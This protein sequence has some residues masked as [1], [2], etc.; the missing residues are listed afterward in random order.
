L[1]ILILTTVGIITFFADIE[2]ML[3]VIEITGLDS[4]VSLSFA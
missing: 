4:F 1:V 3:E 2:I